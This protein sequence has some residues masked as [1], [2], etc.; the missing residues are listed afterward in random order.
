ML[1]CIGLMKHLGL[2]GLCV[3]LTGRLGLMGLCIGL[4]GRL[5]LTGL[6][7]CMVSS[8]AVSLEEAAL[9]CCSWEPLL[10][11]LQ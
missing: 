6:R 10:P 4:T 3:G 1:L 5:G 7:S 9:M 11:R 8:A 2:T